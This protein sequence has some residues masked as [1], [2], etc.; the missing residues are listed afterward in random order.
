MHDLVRAGY[1]VSI[2]FGEDH[3]YDLV[4]EKDGILSRV[5]VKT[6]RLRNGVVMF[7]CY[8]SHGRVGKTAATEVPR[9][10]LGAPS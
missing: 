1:L 5:Q 2:P 10:A 6:G 7:N 3:R 8:S 4:V 9:L